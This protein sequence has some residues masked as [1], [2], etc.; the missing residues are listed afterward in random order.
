MT[1]PMNSAGVTTSTAIIGSSRTGL[2]FCAAFLK[3]QRAGD[4]EGHV[5]RVDLV[6]A[7]VDQGDLDVDDG[8]AG[9]DAGA[10][11]LLDAS[12]TDGMYSLGMAPPWMRLSNS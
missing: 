2:A 5:R 9:E 4:L 6:V 8:V 11:R 10:H 3:R 1:S 12:S 7:A